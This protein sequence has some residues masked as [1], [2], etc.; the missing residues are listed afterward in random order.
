MTIIEIAKI[1]SKGQ[2]T[3]P[4]PVRKILKL[5]Q[6]SYVC[7]ALAKTGIILTPC[8]V[9]VKSPYASSKEWTRAKKQYLPKRSFIQLLKE[10]RINKL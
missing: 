5:K 4:N 1:T 10:I 7:F 3:I 2:V 9:S 8:K 6:G